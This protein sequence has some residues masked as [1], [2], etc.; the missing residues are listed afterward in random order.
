M[1]RDSLSLDAGTLPSVS[2]AFRWQRINLRRK[3]AGALIG[4]IA[5]VGLLVVIIVYQLTG[6]ALRRQLD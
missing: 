5:L 3:I 1:V 6:G 4:I 2:P